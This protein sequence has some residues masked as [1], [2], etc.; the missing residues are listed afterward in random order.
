MNTQTLSV[1]R[2]YNIISRLKQDKVHFSRLLILALPIAAQNFVQTLLN[3][4]DT[5]MIGQLGETS[6]AAVALSN[7]I[8]FL[9]MLLLFGISSGSAV[10]T[11]QFWGKKDME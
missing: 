11:A 10:F 8:F 4:V 5:L 3:L 1:S 9:I 2:N 7:Q 6:I